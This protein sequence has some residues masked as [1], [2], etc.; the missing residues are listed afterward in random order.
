MAPWLAMPNLPPDLEFETGK[1]MSNKKSRIVLLDDVSAAVADKAAGT[2]R[3]ATLAQVAA[4]AGVNE[5]A[6]LKAELSKKAFLAIQQAGNGLVAAANDAEANVP[7]AKTIYVLTIV[8][9][10]VVDAL[11]ALLERENAGIIG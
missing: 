7:T 6:V 3:E 11:A 1:N 8:Q 10:Y 5:Q 9:G 4:D 2:N